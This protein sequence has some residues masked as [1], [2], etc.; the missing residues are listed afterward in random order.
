MGYIEG[1]LIASLA[2]YGQ[3][4]YDETI[5]GESMK[6]AIA[7][8]FEKSK[9]EYYSVLSYDDC[10]E[11]SREIIEREDFTPRS[12]IVFLV[13]YYVSEGENISSYATSYDYHTAIRE[14]CQGLGRVIREY[15]PSALFRGYGDHSP[16]DEIHA[17]S[18]CGLGITG[19]NYLLI[20]EKYGSYVFVGDM[21]TDIEAE[22]LGRVEPR[23]GIGCM[24]CGACRAVCPTG[25]LR[26][27]SDVCL[28]AITQRKGALT[29]DERSMMLR[30]NTAWGCDI[31]Q[32]VCPYNRDVSPTPLDFFHKDRITRL[33][34]EM[35]DGMKKDELRSRAFGWRGRRV[36]ERNLD[37]LEDK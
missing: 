21:I 34:R 26:G 7:R 16:I 30:C 37:V 14:I 19:D 6:D 27:E 20:N 10:H 9:I 36:V 3:I 17:A 12:V 33:T 13:P 5:G 1:I 29:D 22:E 32:R 15:K 8:Y 28:S 24:H 31:C 23:G 25:I 11:I 35:L 2:F 18:I 4:C